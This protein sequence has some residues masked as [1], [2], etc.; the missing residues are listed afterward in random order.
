MTIG[1]KKRQNQI[2]TYTILFLIAAFACYIFFLLE[3]KTLIKYTSSNADGLTQTYT[4]YVAIKHMIQDLLNGKGIPAWSWALGLGGDTFEYYGFKLFNPLTYLIIA[5]PDNLIDVGYSI[6]TVLRQYL[7]GLTFLLCAREFK[8]DSKQCLLG[9]MTYAFSGW[10]VEL[11]FNQGSFENAA[12]VLPLLIMGT[13][14]FFQKKSPVLFI[15]SVALCLTTGVTWTYI[16]GIVVVAYYLCR[17]HDYYDIRNIKEVLTNTGKY[18]YY[19]IIGLFIT[20]P[21]IA[22]ILSS[23]GGA[24]IDTE[25]KTNLF[26]FSLKKYLSIPGGLFKYDEVGA[27]SYSYIF[28]SALCVALLPLIVISAKKKKSTIARIACALSILSLIPATSKFFNGFSYPAGRWYYVLVFFVVMAAIEC[29]DEEFLGNKKYI[30][31]MY[32][33][34]VALVTFVLVTFVLGIGT[35]MAALTTLFGGAIGIAF[36]YIASRYYGKDKDNQGNQKKL[37]ILAAILLLAS[38]TYPAV[39]RTMPMLSNYLD[40]YLGVGES[41]ELLAISSERVAPELAKQD[42][43][44]YRTDQAYRANKRMR[45]KLKTNANIVYNN[46]SVYMYSSIIDSR[47]SK[48]NKVLGNNIGYYSRTNVV[49]ND[50]RTFIDYL[51]GVK[52]Y[53]GDNKDEK[54]ASKYA[55]YGYEKTGKIDGVTIH[56]NEHCIGLGT[57]MEQYITESELMEYPM[58]VRD[59]VMLQAA[60]VPDDEVENLKGIKHADKSDIKTEIKELDCQVKRI[61]R[62]VLIKYPEVDNAQ[63]VVSIEGLERDLARGEERENYKIRF[64]SNGIKKFAYCEKGSPRGFNDVTEYNVNMGRSEELSNTIKV[65]FIKPGKYTYDSIKVYAIP[66]T[67]LNE[68]MDKLENNSF[69][70]DEDWDDSDS[71]IISGEINSEKGGILYLSIPYDKTWKSFLWDTDS[72]VDSD[73][74]LEVI[75]TNIAFTGII[76][77][78]GKHTIVVRYLKTNYFWASII[79]GILALIREIITGRKKRN[80]AKQD[81]QENIISA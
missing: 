40:G 12:I 39:G 3:G 73:E 37:V 53:L 2:L 62:K 28:I 49:S 75:N 9:A 60:V 27:T 77:P 52:Y 14:K 6:A 20:T 32:A 46:K 26:A 55:G 54:N 50:N 42:K 56:R 41:A 72:D 11:V 64:K 15:V 58:L 8:F 16:S 7:A 45:T 1:T 5:F 57:V 48:F 22:A 74:F 30:N 78:S 24:T 35:K 29:L 21:F 68:N 65:N 79:V 59:Q 17:Y 44:F 13:E 69:K 31:I 66:L 36:T 76:V 43:S 67:V 80:A 81:K 47:W 19:G 18:I 38:V 23:M 4:S 71:D 34:L 33:W 51:L 70:L 10:M 61:K 63:I 25:A